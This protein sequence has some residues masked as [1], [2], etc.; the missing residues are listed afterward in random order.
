[1]EGGRESPRKEGKHK[2]SS[3]Y[4]TLYNVLFK[5]EIRLK[6]ADKVKADRR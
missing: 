5:N 3:P 4:N 2:Q 6:K 1:M